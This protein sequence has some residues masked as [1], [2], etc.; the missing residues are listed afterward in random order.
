MDLIYFYSHILGIWRSLGRGLSPSC[1][2]TRFFYP[3]HQARD[4][5]HA[6]T[7]TWE[8]AVRFLTHCHSGNSH[9]TQFYHIARNNIY[10]F[11]SWWNLGF[12][13]CREKCCYEH[14]STNFHVDMFS[15]LWG[16]DIFLCSSCR[17]WGPM[18]WLAQSY[19]LAHGRTVPSNPGVFDFKHR[20]LS[21]ILGYT[22]SHSCKFAHTY[23]LH[24]HKRCSK[25]FE[26]AD[27]SQVQKFSKSNQT[28]VVRCWGS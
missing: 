9:Y 17:N 11:F 18:R 27:L 12:I 26:P 21:A 24:K 6:S 14:S 20:G 23:T 28:E 2:H 4:W 19:Q 1:G 16:V 10:P 25:F 22:H 5:A 15:F 3:L 7:A 13:C 8:A